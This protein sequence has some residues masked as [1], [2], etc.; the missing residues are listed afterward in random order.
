MNRP[1]TETNIFFN[2]EPIV[3]KRNNRRTVITQDNNGENVNMNQV[4]E[5]Y[6]KRRQELLQK[7]KEPPKINEKKNM[8]SKLRVFDPSKPPTN[9]QLRNRLFNTTP[10]ERK[11]ANRQ[12]IQN[13]GTQEYLNEAFK[14]SMS[15]RMESK[16]P[17]R[18]E[19]ILYPFKPPTDKNIS[20][21]KA[22]NKKNE[23]E[24]ETP[25]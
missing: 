10:E 8:F 3:S 20:N 24:N 21:R 2:T 19:R 11:Q 13:Q 14:R 22:K 5:E 17:Q 1:P 12:T 7:S 6:L 18:R 23:N 25:I 16:E 15:A 9:E 4:T